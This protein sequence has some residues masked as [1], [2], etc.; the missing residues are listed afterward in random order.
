M[1]LAGCESFL[2]RLWDGMDAFRVCWG[3]VSWALVG[4]SFGHCATLRGLK[5][6]ELWVH[7][8]LHSLTR[9]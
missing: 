5:L 9:G 2:E 6:G 8:C 4:A 1:G 3:F 7:S